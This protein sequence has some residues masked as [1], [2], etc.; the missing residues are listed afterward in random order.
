MLTDR[1]EKEEASWVDV[2]AGTDDDSHDVGGATEEEERNER[3]AGCR[4]VRGRGKN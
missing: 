4:R 1:T 2:L 3:A